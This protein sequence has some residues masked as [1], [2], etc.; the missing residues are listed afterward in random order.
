MSEATTTS[1]RPKA[2]Q[3]KP[4]P[5]TASFEAFCERA[6][7]E[8]ARLIA[9]ATNPAA[10]HPPKLSDC[11]QSLEEI[12]WLATYHTST[13]DHLCQAVLALLKQEGKVSPVIETLLD[14]A[15]SHVQVLGAHVDNICTRNGAWTSVNRETHRERGE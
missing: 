9:R 14:E 6:D 11:L 4:K 12:E 13:T 2:Q 5:S 10:K 1:R 8:E 15:R 7:Q 3:D